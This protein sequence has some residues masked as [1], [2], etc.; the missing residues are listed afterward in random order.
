MVVSK[1]HSRAGSKQLSRA[2]LGR[3]L[4]CPRAVVKDFAHDG[5]MMTTMTLVAT[6][7]RPQL[8]GG[9]PNR[10]QLTAVATPRW[11]RK[12]SWRKRPV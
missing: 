3:F 9:L 8:Q 6:A 4:A 11:L 10:G 1:R 7:F 12:G 2:G 5:L